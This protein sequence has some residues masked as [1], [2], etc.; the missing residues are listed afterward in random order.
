[1]GV[2]ITS[3]GCYK[4]KVYVSNEIWQEKFAPAVTISGY[5]F[6]RTVTEDIAERY[7]A[8]PTETVVSMASQA[9][10]N[11]LNK[12]DVPAEKIGILIHTSN[13]SDEIG[14]DCTKIQEAV[15]AIHAAAYELTDTACAG[16]IVSLF[17]AVLFI[18]SGL[19]DH[20]LVSCVGNAASRGGNMRDWMSCSMGELAAAT[21]LSRCDGDSGLLAYS[22]KTLGE[23]AEIFQFIPLSYGAM[24]W[25]G[26][27]KDKYWANL[28]HIIPAQGLPD[29]QKI[30]TEYASEIVKQTIR[31]ANLSQTDI[32]WLVTHHVGGFLK[33]WRELFGFDKEQHLNTYAEIGNSS[34][35]N[36][37]YTL[38]KAMDEGKFA[39][40]DKILLFSPGT[41]V[42][43]ASAIWKW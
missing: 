14:G 40:E 18:E 16:F 13:V 15:G 17:Q 10:R 1:M 8:S 36:I 25:P 2:K 22:H 29:M 20:A 11:C 21:L 34:M 41:G 12:A 19:Y 43:L 23:F 31:S 7:Y 32:Q 4:P 28:Y 24:A 26:A 27:H 6:L 35:C 37:P 3:I 42:H 9:I 38:M 33:I 5:E 39:A 30:S